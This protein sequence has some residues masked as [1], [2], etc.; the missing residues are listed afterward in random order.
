MPSSPALNLSQYQGLF[1]WVV[2]LH[3]VTKILELQ[4]QHQSF[5]W[6]FRVN[7]PSHWLVWSLCCP[8]DFH[9]SSPAP[10]FEG[11]NFLAFCVLY[12]PALRTICDPPGKTIDLTIRTFVSR[13][14]SLLSTHWLGLSSLSCQE[15]VVF[16]FH[17]C[18][19]CVQW[20]WSPRRENLSLL[21]PFPPLFAVQYGVRCH[22]LS[23]FFFNLVLSQ[24]FHS[25]PS[26]SS[27]GS[28]FPLHFLRLKWYHPH[29][30]GCWCFSHLSWFR[31]V[32]HPAQHFSWYAQC[33]G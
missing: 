16:W 33:V 15:A 27:R 8:G 14:M 25:P 3:Q 9:K 13:V 30:W 10:Q 11:I 17:G 5:Q 1:Q 31:L 22:Y 12:H 24:L 18:N 7:L 6:I 32:S 21:L 19:H 23:F 2:C 26:P 20:F 28:L 29:I 4:L